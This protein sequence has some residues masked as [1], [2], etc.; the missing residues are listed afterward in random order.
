MADGPG[1]AW[2]Q[3]SPARLPVKCSRAGLIASPA[4]LTALSG[5]RLG[6]Q[7]GYQILR[8]LHAGPPDG[9]ADDLA[10]VRPVTVAS[11]YLAAL[12]QQPFRQRGRLEAEGEE[13]VVAHVEV[14]LLGLTARVGQVGDVRLH[15][16]GHH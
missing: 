16:V 10:R 11:G 15:R 9:T 12:F 6:R 1:L 14:V 4:L 2:D 13:L 8:G 3:A 5:L 7:F